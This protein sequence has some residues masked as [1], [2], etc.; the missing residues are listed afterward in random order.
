M[1]KLQPKAILA[2]NTFSDLEF[3]FA[4]SFTMKETRQAHEST[5]IKYIKPKNRLNNNTALF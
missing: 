1:I 4:P 3:D 2:K 5:E